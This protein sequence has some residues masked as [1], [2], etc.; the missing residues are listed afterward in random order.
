MRAPFLVI[1]KQDH[2]NVINATRYTRFVFCI[3][4]FMLHPNIL[5]FA[6]PMC[7][8]GVPVCPSVRPEQDPVRLRAQQPLR[9]P[10][11]LRYR[12]PPRPGPPP[13]LLTAF[14]SLR[15]MNGIHFSILN[16]HNLQ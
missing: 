10:R 2:L 8:L 3:F 15:I 12:P 4:L 14:M 11:P 7:I 1:F 9:V 16:G 6:D 13:G 5:N